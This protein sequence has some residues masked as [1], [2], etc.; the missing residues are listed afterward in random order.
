MNFT[1]LG[2]ACFQLEVGGKKL[3]VDPF[4]T[5]NPLAAHI[6][7]DE[8]EVDYILISHAHFDHTAD[9]EAIAKRTGATIISNYEIYSKYQKDGLSKG[10]PMNIGGKV[11]LD[12]GTVTMTEAVHSS[13]FADGTYGGSPG[14]FVIEGDGKTIYYSGDT[15]L[16]P[17]IRLVGDLFNVDTAILPVGDLFTMGSDHAAMAAKWV[18]VKQA[19]GVHFD[20]FPPIKLDRDAAER[21]FRHQGIHLAIPEIGGSIEL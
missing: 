8:L 2:H 18:G 7:I 13:S 12:F 14:G 6:N 5:H 16:S 3:L 9:V 20:T 19:I 11:K 17:C 21:A 4:I 1:F 10:I 15:A